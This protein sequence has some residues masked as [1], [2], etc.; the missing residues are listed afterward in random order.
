M[1]EYYICA[2]ALGTTST[3]PPP[4]TP[5]TLTAF[6]LGTHIW[7]LDA[8]QPK[9]TSRG[10]V[11]PCF[12]GH[13]CHQLETWDILLKKSSEYHPWRSSLLPGQVLDQSQDMLSLTEPFR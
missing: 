11:Q 2:A 12:S 8:Q 9:G 10:H 5:L 7:I 1:R 13:D 4:R 3:R 6:H